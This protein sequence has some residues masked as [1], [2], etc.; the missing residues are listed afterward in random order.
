MSLAGGAIVAIWNDI[1]EE[2]RDNFYEWHNREHIPERV[3]IAGF[4]RG[5]RYAALV[6]EP[7]YFTLYEVEDQGVLSGRP[8]LERLNQPTRWTTE[9]VRHFRNVSR[10]LCVKDWSRGAGSGGFVGTIRFDSDP[11][12]DQALMADLTRTLTGLLEGA[13]IVGAHVCRAD[14]T[15]SRTRT[16]EQEGRPENAVPRWVILIEGSTATAT[17]PGLEVVQKEISLAGLDVVHL[18]AGAYGLQ[19]DMLTP[20]RQV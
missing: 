2:G 6:G 4:L 1:T 20:N 7:Q 16:A 9:S 11:A 3:S 10:S 17:G 15:A 5:R 13:G 18:A 19:V 14:Q 8:Y 12:R